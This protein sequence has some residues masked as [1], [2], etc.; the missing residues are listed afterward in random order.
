MSAR[1]HGVLMMFTFRKS[2]QEIEEK[3]KELEKE[4]KKA[5]YKI[6]IYRYDGAI[7]ALRW[8]LYARP[9]EI[10]ENPT[11]KMF[12]KLKEEIKN[13]KTIARRGY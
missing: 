4:K 2:D 8:A 9:K 12:R 5:V 10:I 7:R 11:K 6:Q 13:E 3:I 1:A